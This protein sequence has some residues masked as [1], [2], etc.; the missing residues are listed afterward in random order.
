MLLTVVCTRKKKLNVKKV[1]WKPLL[2]AAVFEELGM[3]LSVALVFML[4]SLHVH[5]I[6]Y[7]SLYAIEQHPY[8]SCTSHSFFEVKGRYLLLKLY[9]YSYISLFTFFISVCFNLFLFLFTACCAQLIALHILWLLC[10]LPL[11]SKA[12]LFWESLCLEVLLT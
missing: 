1:T 11:T 8:V 6:C 4:A 10:P 3:V 5:V 2:W 9:C 7:C 12:D